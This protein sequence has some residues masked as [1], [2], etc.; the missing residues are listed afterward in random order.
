MFSHK[1]GH[2]WD[3]HRSGFLWLAQ[4]GDMAPAASGPPSQARIDIDARRQALTMEPGSG[5]SVATW[6]QPLG[7]YLT[8]ALEPGTD[9]SIPIW[10]YSDDMRIEGAEPVNGSFEAPGEGG[11]SRRLGIGGRAGHVDQ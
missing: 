2:T 8:A 7:C 1:G 10:T 11:H 3:V 4:F 5:C 9:D 6:A